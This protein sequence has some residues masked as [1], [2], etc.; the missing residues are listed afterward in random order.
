MYPVYSNL[1]CLRTDVTLIQNLKLKIMTVYNYAK[2]S[3]R[4]QESL[5]NSEGLYLDLYFDNENLI[6]VYYLNGFFIEV[7]LCKGMVI[8]IL[9]YKR[10][11]EMDKRRLHAIQKRNALLSLAA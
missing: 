3:K 4:E 5:L 11:Y 9:P 1:K 6:N 2:L 10:G 8:D 7:V